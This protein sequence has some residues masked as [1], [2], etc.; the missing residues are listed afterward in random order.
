MGG[1]AP[2]EFTLSR[3]H[4]PWT[5]A[6]RPGSEASPSPAHAASSR[7]AWQAF[8]A[9]LL[10]CAGRDTKPQQDRNTRQSPTRRERTAANWISS[11]FGWTAKRGTANGLE[12]LARIPS[13]RTAAPEKPASLAAAIALGSEKGKAMT[14]GGAWV[15]FL[16]FGL[17]G[18]LGIFLLGMELTGDGLKEVAGERMRGILSAITSNRVLGLLLG[19]VITAVLQS[20]SA[21][22]VLLVGFVEATMMTLG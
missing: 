20:S 4:D 15:M 18:G 1:G 11:T 16:V 21:A 2:R 10:P 9:P 17:L 19:V 5:P 14:R 7:F 6:R 22:S 12:R 13:P 3:S 8:L